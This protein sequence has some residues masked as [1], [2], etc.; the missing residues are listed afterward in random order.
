MS[1]DCIETDADMSSALADRNKTAV[2]PYK[3]PNCS[4]SLPY[5]TGSFNHTNF[6]DDREFLDSTESLDYT[7]PTEP[8]LYYAET[9]DPSPFAF[10][11]DITY[12]YA[13]YNY[14][15]SYNCDPRFDYTD[16]F[17]NYPNCSVEHENHYHR[18][19]SIPQTLKEY[20]HNVDARECLWF[21]GSRTGACKAMLGTSR[22]I[23]SCNLAIAPPT[24]TF[25]HTSQKAETRHMCH[26][27]VVNNAIVGDIVGSM[28]DVPRSLVVLPFRY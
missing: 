13:Y 19:V 9:C 17:E 16:I 24:P 6:L 21:A 10:W 1:N 2:F 20:E 28:L 5:Y 4:E 8:S 11:D 7:L 22:G 18:L 26:D 3:S 15:Y 25:G 23:V 27:A 12:G 14:D